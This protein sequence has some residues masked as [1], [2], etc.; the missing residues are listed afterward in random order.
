M[1]GGNTHTHGGVSGGSI[2]MH[3]LIDPSIE[4]VTTSEVKTV[5]PKVLRLAGLTATGGPARGQ[6]NRVKRGRP[7]PGPADP[8]RLRR[9]HPR[10]PL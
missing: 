10:K 5:R 2:F 4:S 6:T 1:G 8:R 7:G 9:A 3:G